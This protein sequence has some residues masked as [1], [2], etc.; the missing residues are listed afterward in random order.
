MS[1]LVRID[2]RYQ[3]NIR[4]YM[5]FVGVHTGTREQLLQSGIRVLDLL[6]YCYRPQP[7]ERE[8]TQED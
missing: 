4:P 2:Y 5:R 3:M 7:I 1:E 8:F 6:S